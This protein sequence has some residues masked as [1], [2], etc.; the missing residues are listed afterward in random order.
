MKGFS[1]TISAVLA[2]LTLASGA[3]ATVVAKEGVS[4]FQT[5]DD[6][7]LHC[8]V[9]QTTGDITEL[10]WGNGWSA[11]S[12]ALLG[13][14]GFTNIVATTGYYTSFDGYRHATFATALGQVWSYDYSPSVGISFGIDTTFAPATYGHIVS[15][16]SYVTSDH[17]EHIVVATD[18]RKVWQFRF[19]NSIPGSASIEA[20]GVAYPDPI[21]SVST[22]PDG[23]GGAWLYVSTS[24]ASRG[25][26]FVDVGSSTSTA[27]TPTTIPDSTTYTGGNV[28]G[29]KITDTLWDT[30]WA[31]QLDWGYGILAFGPERLAGGSWHAFTYGPSVTAYGA[32]KDP[33]S[34]VHGLTAMSNGDIWDMFRSGGSTTWI[35]LGIF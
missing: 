17:Y 4:G 8:I 28:I 25:G 24:S 32:F 34:G 11:P 10:Y 31:S 12:S 20:I 30:S 9:A 29:V 33:T 35:K 23:S 13:H 16:S 5:P 3:Q 27:N 22:V 7:Y 18:Q 1:T 15:M 19:N 26:N 6:S 21:V 2:A 14:S